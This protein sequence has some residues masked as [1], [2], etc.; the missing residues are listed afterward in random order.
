MKILVKI[1]LPIKVDIHLTKFVFKTQ[2]LLLL[3]IN[4]R[5]PLI[6]YCIQ[7]LWNQQYPQLHLTQR[8]NI[9]RS[10]K[11]KDSYTNLTIAKGKLL[12]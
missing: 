11:S 4:I 12:T 7:S 8:I 2:L 6:Y 1:K 10:G 9:L 3:I 5:L